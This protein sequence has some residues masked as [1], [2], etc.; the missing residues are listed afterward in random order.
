MPKQIV[1]TSNEICKQ[2]FLNGNGSENPP[3]Y[4]PQN[5]GAISVSAPVGI[6]GTNLANDV[7]TIQ[8]ALNR[9]S[10]AEGGASPTLVVDGICGQKT[11]DAIQ[12]FQLQQFGW[13][14]ADG[15]INPGG[16]TITRL[17]EILGANR[18]ADSGGGFPPVDDR[19]AN[20]IFKVSMTAGLL[21]AKRWIRAAQANLDMALVY[22]DQPDVPA[23]IPSFGR[24]ERMRLVNRYFKI[25]A[26]KAE[27]KQI[28]IQR[29]RLVFSTMLQMFER[30]GGLWGEK[31]FEIDSTGVTHKETPHAVAHTDVGGFF[32]GGQPN[33]FQKELRGDSIFFVREN[34]IYFTNMDKGVKTI[35]HEMAHF[36]GDVRIGWEIDDFDAYGEPEDARVTKLNSSQRV[37]HADTYARF[38]RAAGN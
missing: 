10:P 13:S 7:T 34:I 32:K 2:V 14:G 20:D 35:V 30:P 21:T 8:D 38:A 33:Q 17:N 12:K 16:Q 1:S 15:K 24:G 25:D 26:M 5:G 9:V 6:G 11:K 4:V 29:I 31:A 19:Q 3:S 18:P 27:Q 36:C 23:F 37:R 28:V 22:V